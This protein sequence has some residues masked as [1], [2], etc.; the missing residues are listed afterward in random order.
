VSLDRG[1]DTMLVV[2]AAI[3]SNAQRRT[4]SIDPK[5]ALDLD[6]LRDL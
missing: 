6:A 4:V 5:A 3:Q 2:A 1:L